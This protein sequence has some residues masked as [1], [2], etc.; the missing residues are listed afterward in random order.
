MSLKI[1][2]AP[3]LSLLKKTQGCQVSKHTL[4]QPTSQTIYTILH[5]PLPY[6]PLPQTPLVPFGFSPFHF[7]MSHLFLICY[8]FENTFFEWE[9]SSVYTGVSLLYYS[10]LNKIYLSTFNRHQA[11]FLLWHLYHSKHQRRIWRKPFFTFVR[12]GVSVLFHRN[13][14]QSFVDTENLTQLAREEMVDGWCHTLGLC[15][16]QGH[17]ED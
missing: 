4:S 17:D 15:T 12:F 7:S 10:H 9:L 5:W 6:F 2:P 16:R 13:L 8:P 11:L 1:T 14:G 3:V